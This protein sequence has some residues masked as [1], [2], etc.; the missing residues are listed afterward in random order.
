MEVERGVGWKA[1]G[2]GCGEAL[3]KIL[4]Q[5]N[6]SIRGSQPREV[7]W[8]VLSLMEGIGDNRI[9][10]EILWCPLHWGPN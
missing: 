6:G 5:E 7:D 3:W 2:T 9:C 8:T 4:K 1:S 10:E